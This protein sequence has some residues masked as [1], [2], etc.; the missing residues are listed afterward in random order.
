MGIHRIP[1]LITA[2]ND[3]RRTQRG[4]RLSAFRLCPVAPVLAFA[5]QETEWRQQLYQL[6]FEHAQA[7][8]HR[9]PPSEGNW[10]TVGN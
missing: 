4:I 3:P 8:A 2:E 7:V 1:E 6:A 5:A 9:P 10:I